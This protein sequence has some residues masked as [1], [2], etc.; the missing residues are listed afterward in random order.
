MLLVEM[1]PEEIRDVFENHGDDLRRLDHAIEVA[2]DKLE[3]IERKGEKAKSPYAISKLTAGLSEEE[4]GRI[5]DHAIRLTN[6]RAQ[7]RAADDAL[8][9]SARDIRDFQKI[10]DEATRSTD[11]LN[12]MLASRRGL[13]GRLRWLF[14]GK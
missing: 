2:L 1:T 14:F 4:R 12:K 13:L 7:R 6:V 5:I 9:M 3:W 10:L 11:E 8:Q